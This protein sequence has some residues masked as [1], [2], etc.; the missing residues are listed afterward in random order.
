MKILFRNFINYHVTIIFVIH[1]AQHSFQFK[2]N[3]SLEIYQYKNSCSARTYE[4]EI[5]KNITLK[6]N[7]NIYYR[8]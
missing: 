5:Y 3:V 2:A 8:D 1:K 7:T 6:N 4:Y